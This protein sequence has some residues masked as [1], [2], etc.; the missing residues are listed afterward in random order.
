MYLKNALI[1][2]LDTVSFENITIKAICQKA[3]VNRSTFYAYYS[4]PRD[5]IEEIESDIISK[6]VNADAVLEE[7]EFDES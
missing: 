1:E 7:E 5:L 2:L 6:L 4:C 3:S